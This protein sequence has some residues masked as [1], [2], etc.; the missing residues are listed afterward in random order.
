MVIKMKKDDKE[1][2]NTNTK[3]EKKKNVRKKVKTRESRNKT[4]ILVFLVICLAAI[5]LL[6]YASLELNKKNDE[7]DKHL[8]E[9]TYT[10]LTKKIDKKESFILVVTRTDCSHCATY[11]PVLKQVLKDYDLIAY[12]ISSDKMSEDEKAKFK[13]IANVTGTPTTIFIENGEET[14][15][16]N[17]L[18]GAVNSNRII[19]RLKSLGY[20]KE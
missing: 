9:L 3:D 7:L 15:V 12:E 13:D 10:E 6:V 4:I 14:T 19:N 2:D 11:K 16:N 18:V 5:G 20:I 8:I 17:R 1:L